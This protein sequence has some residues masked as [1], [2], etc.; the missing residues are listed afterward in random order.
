M[1]HYVR[2]NYE[3]LVPPSATMFGVDDEW[4]E[5]ASGQPATAADEAFRQ[6]LADAGID[7]GSLDADDIGVETGR[8]SGGG[9]FCRDLIRR[10]VLAK[11]PLCVWPKAHT[12]RCRGCGWAQR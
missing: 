6:W 12:T 11:K 7:R 4:I 10:N 1:S 3:C 5:V 8:T 9:D 2:D